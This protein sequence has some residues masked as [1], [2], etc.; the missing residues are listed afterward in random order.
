MIAKAQVTDMESMAPCPMDRE[1]AGRTAEFDSAM[2][3]FAMGSGGGSHEVARARPA[4][5]KAS[6]SFQPDARARRAPLLA[7]VIAARIVPRLILAHRPDAASDRRPPAARPDARCISPHDVLLLGEL[8]LH[9][10]LEPALAHVEA[11]VERGVPLEVIYID[12][13]SPAA[14]QLGELWCEDRLSF[15]EVT[16]GQVALQ[17]L[18]RAFSGMFLRDCPAPNPRRRVLLSPLPGEQHA[19]GHFMVCDFFRRA[20]WQVTGEP[21]ATRAALLAAV[22]ESWFEVIGIS[23]SSTGRMREL[24]TLIRAVRGVSRNGGLAVMVGGAPFC[25]RPALAWQVGADASAIDACH[26]PARAEALV[27]MLQASA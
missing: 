24:G 26:A 25:D 15:A 21:F 8:V 16:I 4:A 11:L 10:E 14:R 7:E 20:G 27:G 18:Q 13:L 1:I 17:R 2:G 6:R 22:S 9:G 3:M 12:L 23:L 5:A 19:F